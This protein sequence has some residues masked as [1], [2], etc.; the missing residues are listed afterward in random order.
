SPAQRA[1]ALVGAILRRALGTGQD[2]AGDHTAGRDAA[3]AGTR[4]RPARR[5]PANRTVALI[6]AAQRRALRVRADQTLRSAVGTG[7]AAGAGAC[8]RRTR[9]RPAERAIALVGSVERGALRARQILAGD[10]STRG[11]AA[12]AGGGW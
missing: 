8:G 1:V 3:G 7:D 6:G 10:E 9:E 12:S 5:V 11:D 2:L 4:R